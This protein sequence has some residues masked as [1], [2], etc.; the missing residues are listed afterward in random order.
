MGRGR[1]GVTPPLF[2]MGGVC[3][4][5]LPADLHT[6]PMFHGSADLCRGL[7]VPHLYLKLCRG[8]IV[9]MFRVNCSSGSRCGRVI[10]EHL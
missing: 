4:M 7:V 10:F 9:Q 6:M 2:G 5:C 1:G 8:L 3:D